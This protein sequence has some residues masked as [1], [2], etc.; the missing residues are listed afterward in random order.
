MKEMKEMNPHTLK[1]M[2][3]IKE[4]NPHTLK[5]MKKMK[6]MNSTSHSST[7][8]YGIPGIPKILLKIPGIPGIHRN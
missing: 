1:E 3:E 5:E 4:M 6:E 8:S 7:D 2:K